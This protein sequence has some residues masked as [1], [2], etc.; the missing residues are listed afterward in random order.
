MN[1]WPNP[2]RKKSLYEAIPLE[3]DYIFQE[4]ILFRLC[5]RKYVINQHLKPR[6]QFHPPRLW[7]LTKAADKGQGGQEPQGH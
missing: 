3:R 7:L 2:S 5:N 6:T 4:E 1:I